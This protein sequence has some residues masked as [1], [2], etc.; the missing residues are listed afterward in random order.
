MGRVERQGITR[1]GGQ[2]F[3]ISVRGVLLMCRL[4]ASGLL[5]R[6]MPR[7]RL[8]SSAISGRINRELAFDHVDAAR[9]FGFKPRELVLCVDDLP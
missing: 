3:Q 5:C 9:D 4:W 1:R 2:S 8:W 7:R 6:R